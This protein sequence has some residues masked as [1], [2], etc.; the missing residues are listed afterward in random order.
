MSDTAVLEL[1]ARSDAAAEER[2]T[3]Y[4]EAGHAVV[5]ALCGERLTAIEI[6]GDDEHWGSVRALRFESAPR[7]EVDPRVPTAHLERRILCALAGMVAES[8]A[9]GRAG[10]DERSEDLDV[11]VRLA[12]RV[13]GDCERVL[14]YL[15]TARDHL[16][17]LLCRHWAAV[18][19][20]AL[21]LMARRE[22]P[23]D[24]LRRL[25]GRL[26]P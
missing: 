25:L 20:V 8:I 7:A 19:A 10:W 3:A 21:E 6:R 26:L 24:E 15:E 23:G 2:A 1:E 9:T 13:E 11:A 18:E 22:V 4:H 12:I 5:A 14:S 17:D 16:E